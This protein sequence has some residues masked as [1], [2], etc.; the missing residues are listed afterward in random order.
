MV[1]FMDQISLKNIKEAEQ[2]TQTKVLP[3]GSP[4]ETKD[5]D[6]WSLLYVEINRIT[7]QIELQRR[8][9]VYILSHFRFQRQYNAGQNHDC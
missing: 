9:L 7:V 3:H 2:A 4:D 6:F 5:D 8:C 1:M